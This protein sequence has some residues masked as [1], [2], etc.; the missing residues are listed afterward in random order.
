MQMNE[1]KVGSKY[2]YGNGF[3]L[4]GG[5]YRSLG[6]AGAIKALLERD[7]K[8]DIFCTTSTGA[9]IGALYASGYTPAEIYEIWEK[10][11]I[12]EVLSFNLPDSGLLKPGKIGEMIGPYLR[13]ERLEEL[14]IP[15]LICC[16]CLNDGTQRVFREG[17]LVQLLEAA[18]AVPV[19]FEPVEIDGKQYVDGGLTSN[20]PTQPLEGQCHRLIGIY[21]N[22]VQWEDKIS[23]LHQI[24]HRTIWIALNST[25]QKSRQLCDWYIAPEGLTENELVNRLAMEKFYHAGYDFTSRFLDEQ[26]IFSGR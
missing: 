1:T 5:A 19:V 8:P 7:I 12:R 16:T 3:V 17:K 4:S 26:G 9:I 23:G 20:L 24:I 22:P 2:P 11:P 18:C 6:Q 21:C 10:E 14:P 25:V 15:L 13:H